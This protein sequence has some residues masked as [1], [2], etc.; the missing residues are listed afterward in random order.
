M[1]E[2]KFSHELT[3]LK[4]TESEIIHA[5]NSDSIGEWRFA[6]AKELWSITL[7]SSIRFSVLHCNKH[8]FVP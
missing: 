7:Y 5:A 6:L 1:C 8:A 4:I 3:I 2:V